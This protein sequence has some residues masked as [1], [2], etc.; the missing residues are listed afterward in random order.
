MTIAIEDLEEI[1]LN[2]PSIYQE[3][4]KNNAK[5]LKKTIKQKAIAIKDSKNHKFL[6]TMKSLKS[7]ESNT[8]NYCFVLLSSVSVLFVR[9]LYRNF[10]FALFLVDSL[11]FHYSAAN[12]NLKKVLNK[13][14]VMKNFVKLN[15]IDELE[16]DSDSFRSS[17]MENSKN[18][19][20]EDDIKHGTLYR[21]I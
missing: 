13:F 16:D 11:K 8:L 7:N 20:D 4:M 18:N 17:Y 21:N 10:R 12:V 1:R 6:G 9:L 15:T 19:D 14:Q 5:K 2:Y 3:I